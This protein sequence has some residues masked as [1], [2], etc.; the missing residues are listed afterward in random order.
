MRGQTFEK[1]LLHNGSL[2]IS[3]MQWHWTKGSTCNNACNSR[4]WTT[5]WMKFIPFG[6]LF[7]SLLFSWLCVS[8]GNCKRSHGA[9]L[10]D[11]SNYYPVGVVVGSSPKDTSGFLFLDSFVISTPPYL[12]FF[13][14]CNSNQKKISLLFLMKKKWFSTNLVRMRAYCPLAELKEHK[15]SIKVR[16][17]CDKSIKRITW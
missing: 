13:R 1:L 11:T 2:K 7:T 10:W 3:K 15:S 16:I 6:E 8:F 12:N 17:F 4:N 14:E 5:C 9:R